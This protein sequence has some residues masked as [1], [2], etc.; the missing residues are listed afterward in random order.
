MFLSRL[1]ALLPG[2]DLNTEFLD[3]GQVRLAEGL[4][5]QTGHLGLIAY[6]GYRGARRVCLNIFPLNQAGELP[7]VGCIKLTGLGNWPGVE[8]DQI[9]GEIIRLGVRWEQLGDGVALSEDEFVLFTLKQ[10]VPVICQ[11]LVEIKGHP[12]RCTEIDPEGLPLFFRHCK[13]I[14]GTVASPRLDAI[15]SL[16]FNISRSRAVVI[17]TGGLVKVNRRAVSSTSI[18]IKEGDW[19]SF[20]GHG[21]LEVSALTGKTRKGRQGLLLTKFS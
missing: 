21:E 20:S 11:R 3:P 4:V 18:R 10:L 16:C 7:P 14:K 12:V 8:P 17:I 13:Q 5:K 1:E 19:I 2:Q 6:G 15:L 9:R